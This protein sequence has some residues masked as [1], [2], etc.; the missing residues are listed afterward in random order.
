MHQNHRD[1]T[2][3]PDKLIAALEAQIEQQDKIIHIQ[4]NTINILKEQNQ[5]LMN[6]L[7]RIFNT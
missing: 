7:D 2:G 3:S 6:T 5:E 4:E 1:I